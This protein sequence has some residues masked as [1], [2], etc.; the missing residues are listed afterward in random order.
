M[1][2]LLTSPLSTVASLDEARAI[3]AGL[4]AEDAMPA[5]GP[6][7]FE[8]AAA[9]LPIAVF[10]DGTVREAQVISPSGIRMVVVA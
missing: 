5:F 8:L 10:A 2:H 9:G 4:V 7:F 3:V 6:R 1:G